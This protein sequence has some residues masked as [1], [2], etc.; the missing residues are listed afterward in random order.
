MPGL[1]IRLALVLEH[2]WWAAEP[3]GTPELTLVSSRPWVPPS[4]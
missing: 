2:L 3:D 4:T 1:A